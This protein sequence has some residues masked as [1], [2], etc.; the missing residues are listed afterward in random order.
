MRWSLE[1]TDVGRDDLK[2]LDHM[3]RRQVIDRLEWFS[4]H[5]EQTRP[6]PLHADWKGYFKLRVGDWRVAYIFDTPK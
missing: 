3:V 6:L 4:V 2:K 5:F 1:F